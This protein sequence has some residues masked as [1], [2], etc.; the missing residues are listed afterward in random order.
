MAE[1]R[2]ANDP[3]SQ[4]EVR[5]YSRSNEGISRA[6]LIESLQTETR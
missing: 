1:T 6:A 3:N 5:I 2:I 4:V